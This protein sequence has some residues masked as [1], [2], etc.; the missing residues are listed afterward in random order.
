MGAFLREG[1]QLLLQLDQPTWHKMDIVQEN[2]MAL[3]MRQLKHLHRDDILTLAHRN[4][5]VARTLLKSVLLC[6][7]L[8]V[9]NNIGTR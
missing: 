5:V 9:A 6:K 2:P 3:L 1:I 8:H 4:I 7:C